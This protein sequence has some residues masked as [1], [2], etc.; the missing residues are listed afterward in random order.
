MISFVADLLRLAVHNVIIR[1]S[2]EINLQIL[3]RIQARANLQFLVQRLL[4]N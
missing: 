4:I 1:I 2:V 3:Q